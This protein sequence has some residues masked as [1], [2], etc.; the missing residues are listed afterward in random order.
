MENPELA[1]QY[2]KTQ[3]GFVLDRVT[4]QGGECG[5]RLRPQCLGKVKNSRLIGCETAAVLHG[6]VLDLSGGEVK[7]CRSHGIEVSSP[8]PRSPR[9]S[10]RRMLPSKMCAD[11]AAIAPR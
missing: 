9:L 6:S 7:E 1:Q 5:I 4:I 8:P 2:Q 10:A 3:S 11:T